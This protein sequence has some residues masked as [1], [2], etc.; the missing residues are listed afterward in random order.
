MTQIRTDAHHHLWQ[1]SRGI[2]DWIGDDLHPIRRDFEPDH[3]KP[4]LDH[5]NITRTVLVQ[6]AEDPA[7]NAAMLAAADA[8]EFIAGVVVWVD[9]EAPDAKDQITRLAHHAKVKSLRPVLQGIEDN[10][11]IL[12][13]AVVDALSVLPSLNLCFDA[14]IQPRHLGAIATLGTRLPDL[15]IVIDH[16][17]KPVIRGGQD[18]GDHWRDGMARL[19][20]NPR[21]FCKL[22][23][24]ATEAGPGWSQASLQPVV[25]HLLTHFS[26]ARLMWGSDWPVLEMDGS[27][28]QWVQTTD[29]LLAS[30]STRDRACVLDQT[31]R[32]F[33]R[34]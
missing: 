26:P 7:E 24:L 15:D 20:Q 33:Y 3:L 11:W 9:L 2:Y 30:L 23:G 8:H 22:S 12:R 25:D 21:I 6:A 13:P 27:Y 5:F 19:A 31:A 4:Y 17:A 10:D 14:L 34:L 18:A 28:G 16:A 1:I 32:N 29:A